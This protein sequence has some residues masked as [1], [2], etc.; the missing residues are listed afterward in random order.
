MGLKY[1][2]FLPYLVISFLTILFLYFVV[3]ETKG[4]SF[5]EIRKKYDKLNGVVTVNPYEANVNSAFTID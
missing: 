5:L 4:K 1:L 3:P 2:A